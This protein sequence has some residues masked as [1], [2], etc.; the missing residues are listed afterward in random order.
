M[1][2]RLVAAL[3][4]RHRRWQIVNGYGPAEATVCVTTFD[5][6]AGA[7]IGD[8]ASAPIGFPIA[9]ARCFVLD[10]ALAPLPPGAVGELWIAGASLARGY[11]GR[12]GL[13]AERFIACPFGPPG[14]RMYR[15]GDLARR[16]ADGALEYHGRAD[17]QVK[18]RG[19]RIEPGEVEAALQS[20]APE[21][22][23]QAA[24]LAQPGPDG[25]ARLV[26]YL[27][28]HAGRTVPDAAG[29]RAQLASRVPDAMVPSAFVALTKLPLTPNGKLDRAALPQP[30]LVSSRAYVA[31][32][33]ETEALLCRLFAEVTGMAPVGIHDNFFEIGG[34]S[35]SAMRLVAAL[36]AATGREVALRG[37]FAQPTPAGLAA[38]LSQAA[39]DKAGAI[40]PGAGRLGADEVALSWGQRRMWALSRLDADGGAYNTADVLR[41]TG[42][43]D[44]TALAAALEDVAGRHAPLRMVIETG[45]DGSPLGR[46]RAVSDSTALLPIEPVGE[47]EL[48]DRLAAES[49]RPFDLGAELPLRARLFRLD[50]SQHVLLLVVH[51]HATDGLSGPILLRELGE[52]Y[53]ARLTGTAPAWA[54]L[55]ASYADFAVWQQDWLEGSGE[56]AR[57]AARWRERLAGAPELLSLP[58]DR[59]RRAE[60]A[61]RA[62]SVAIVV[63]PAVMRGLRGLAQAEGT[64]AFAVLLAGFAATLGR[65]ARAEEVVIG[66]PVAGRTRAEAAGLVGFFVNTLALRV[67]LSG[68]PDAAA[69][70]RR[71]RDATVAGLADQELPFERL[72]DEL[73]V[74]R[75]LSHTPVFQ[76]MF[77][78]QEELGDAA[79]VLPGIAV[80]PEPLA[81]SVA[82]FDL[83]LDLAP[84]EDGGVAGALE[85]DADLFDSATADR[86]AACLTR[87]LSGMAATAAEPVALLPLLS[88]EERAAEIETWNRTAVP[89]PESTLID[90][91]EAPAARTPA[92]IAVVFEDRE[93]TYAELHAAANRLAR[94]LAA[95]GIG[96]ESVVGICLPRGVELVVAILAVLKAGAP[97]LPLDPEHPA[98]RRTW[99][100]SDAGAALLLATQGIAAELGWHSA[101]CLDDPDTESEL[102]ELPAVS[103]GSALPIRRERPTD[104]ACLLYTSGSTGTPKAVGIERRNLIAMLTADRI[105][106]C[107]P[108]SPT[109]AW[110]SSIAFDTHVDEFLQALTS[111]GTLL[112][113]GDDQRV[114]P[115][116]LALSPRGMPDLLEL[117]PQIA[118][119]LLALRPSEDAITVSIGGDIVPPRLVAALRERHRRW[120]IVNGYGPAEATVCVT[121]FDCAAGADIGDGASAPIGF[122]IANAR[123]FVLDAA[124]APLPPGAVGE[125]WIAGASL[126]R[127]YIGRPGLTAERFIACPFGPPGARMYRTGD[128]A[129]RRADGALEHHGRADQ[130]V[131]IRGVRIEPGEVEAALQ[132][133]APEDIAQAAVLAQ[134]GPDGVARLVAYLVPHAG[135]TV[136][137]AAGL[138]AQ[139]AS[140][141]PDA[142]VPS[143]FVALT[144]LPLT[145]NGKLDRAALPQPE[146]VSSRAYVA[147]RSETEALLCRLF[148]EVTGMA[149]VG[150][151]DNFFEIG[152]HSLSAM[153]LVALSREAGLAFPASAVFAHQSPAGLAASLGTHHAYD[154]LIPIRPTGH[155]RAI[156]AVHDG[157]GLG[158]EFKAL[159]DALPGRFPV[160]ALRPRGVEDDAEPFGSVEEMAFAYTRAVRS[161]Q[162][163]GPYC[164]IGYCFGACFAHAMTLLLEQEGERVDLLVSIDGLAPEAHRALQQEEIL[165]RSPDP[166]L[167]GKPVHEIET[168]E[169]DADREFL[170]RIGLPPHIV[171]AALRHADRAVDMLQNYRPLVRCCADVLLIRASIGSP[172]HQGSTLQDFLRMGVGYIG[173]RHNG[174]G[175]CYA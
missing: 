10:A 44:P 126:A 69:L 157:F 171:E 39:L 155:E 57:Q 151:H 128:L 64:T 161:V 16:R 152:G 153:R 165:G 118:A 8:G 100:L 121:T 37:V 148:A 76:A 146:L 71:A 19:V 107:L 139:L 88:A 63:P 123:C 42:A 51:H 159:S 95:R 22:I 120:Q 74:A 174:L 32:R 114:E 48:A 68:L 162:P 4:E 105:A 40:V 59:P 99:M 127:G 89:L 61:R 103:P 141:V 175:C 104:L 115:S 150:I 55:A 163:A 172:I 5:C 27:V 47:A 7:D 145:P 149:P 1:P 156:F 81:P 173:L 20:A 106:Y 91:L 97:Y 75:S 143:A 2:P 66:T 65:L 124:L 28:P 85:Y 125:L 3:R 33:S 96:P 166:G 43:L 164:L 80:R 136:P 23:A 83:S 154:P 93:V 21:D 78:W 35:L 14:A 92:A 56:L 101:L 167:A 52:A 112:V 46:L 29:L 77:A 38:A 72:V 73:R 109:I 117:T 49:D 31:P 138:R 34:H 79:L 12:P 11:I 144:K 116:R 142:M 133:A 131:K 70:V 94:A 160:W 62:G 113:L 90:L 41:L 26:A 87:L 135:R 24:V 129:R 137:D 130:Q 119:D 170:E 25:V 9:N 6:A 134:P 67:D 82:M 140:R 30:E 122:P 98:Q 54:P 45:P 110:S 53:A 147:P 132:S 108:E 169:A 158:V 58:T 13:T 50:A 15:T 84:S 18:I 168:E 86:W 111:G 17:Q 102:A 36:R 60:R